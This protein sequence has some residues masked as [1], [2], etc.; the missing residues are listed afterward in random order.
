MYLRDAAFD[1]FYFFLMFFKIILNLPL[2]FVFHYI[3][4]FNYTSRKIKKNRLEFIRFH[5]AELSKI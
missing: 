4:L 2:I 3:F 5:N 1:I